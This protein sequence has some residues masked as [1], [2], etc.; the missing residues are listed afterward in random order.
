MNPLVLSADLSLAGQAGAAPGQ[1]LRQLRRGGGLLHD[2]EW[3]LT[4]PDGHWKL[5][6]GVGSVGG[7]WMT[8][9]QT[10]AWRGGNVG[11]FSSIPELSFSWGG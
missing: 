9:S 3:L 8:S 11:C 4:H 1:R 7:V 6:V 2:V 10:I 5:P